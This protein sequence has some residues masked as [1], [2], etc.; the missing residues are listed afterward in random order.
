VKDAIR[1]QYGKEMKEM[2]FGRNFDIY[3]VDGKVMIHDQL[4]PSI[5]LYLDLPVKAFGIL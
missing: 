1:D 3:E 2:G 5:K 4:N